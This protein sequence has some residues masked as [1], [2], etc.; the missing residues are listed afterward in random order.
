M[1]SNVDL[2][3]MLD[4]RERRALRQRELLAQYRRPMV[5]FTMN[6]AGPVK[7]SPLIRRGYALGRQALMG[8]L[9]RIGAEVLHR[10]EIDEPT[11]CE[12]LWAVDMDAAKLKAVTCEIEDGSELGRLFDMDVLT[13][14]G[15]KLDRPAPRRC[16]ICG[17]PA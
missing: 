3:Q 15:D 7:N 8:Q 1:E 4:A 13:P 6:I 12:G 17:G 10:E 14:E 11:G 5:S 2:M 16:L 9:R